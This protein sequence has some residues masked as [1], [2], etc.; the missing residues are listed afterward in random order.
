MN[1]G[2]GV[3]NVAFNMSWEKGSKPASCVVLS[4]AEVKKALPKKCKNKEDYMFR[5][6]NEEDNE[7]FV[8][9][10][11]IDFKGDIEP[12]SFEPADSEEFE[13]TTTG[14][15]VF[16]PDEVDFSDNWCEYDDKNDESVSVQEMEWRWVRLI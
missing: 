5:A 12:I 10:L 6:L 9:I 3:E 13:V 8:P 2:E 1:H 7:K 15:R 4:V 14:G 16:K 11:A